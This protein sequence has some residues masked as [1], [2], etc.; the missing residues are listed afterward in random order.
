MNPS[1]F[2]EILGISAIPATALAAVVTRQITKLGKKI[3]K[4]EENRENRD[5]LTLKGVL[6]AIDLSKKQAKE[7]ATLGRPN[8]ET[9][10][11]FKYATEIEHNIEDFYMKQGIQNLQ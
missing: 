8:G 11:A 4:R 3:D 1:E 7:L 6:A 5:F 9:E 10:S 2:I